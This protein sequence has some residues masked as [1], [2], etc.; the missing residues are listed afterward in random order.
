ML[1]T[2]RAQGRP[3][4][5]I[6]GLMARLRLEPDDVER[7]A[8]KAAHHPRPG[9]GGMVEV[10]P[11]SE[12]ESSSTGL[13]ARAGTGLLA[14]DPIFPQRDALLDAGIVGPRLAAFLET[15]AAVRWERKHVRYQPTRDLQV[16]YLG[17][18]DSAGSLASLHAFASRESA[19]VYPQTL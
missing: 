9:P 2:E 6:A 17:G 3:R 19:A 1:R 12:V 14:P 5:S 13:P 8:P 15:A 7:P 11:S 4:C 16:L 18:A 10:G